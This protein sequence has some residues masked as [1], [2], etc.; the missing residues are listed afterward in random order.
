M[1]NSE[2]WS[3]GMEYKEALNACQE[4]TACPQTTET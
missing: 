2:F 3:S 1:N 4:T